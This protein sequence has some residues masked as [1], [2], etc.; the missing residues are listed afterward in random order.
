MADIPTG[1]RFSQT[2]LLSPELLPDSARM[3]RRL[4][5]LYGHFDLA[6]FGRHFARELGVPVDLNS[7]KHAYY[8]PPFLEKAD[9]R[10]VLDSITIRYKYLNLGYYDSTGEKLPE[11]K[12]SFLVEARRIFA[13]ERVRYRVDDKGGVHFTV[14][15]E[16]ER[17]RIATLSQ[18]GQ[19]RYAGVKE[20]F[21][22]G[23]TALDSSPP[24]G[25][26]AIR[27]VFFAAESLFRLMY[28]NSPQLNAG[29]VARNS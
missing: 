2:Y 17:S 4:G 29:E 18:L 22:S 12:E 14:D 26:A 28:P 27:G 23:F 5:H 16:F 15:A 21:D 3:R 19:Q 6:D 1:Q 10:D 20:L 8:W 24:D 13:E 25:K 11:V 9:L 7:S